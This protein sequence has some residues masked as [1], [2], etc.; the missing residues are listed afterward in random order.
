MDQGSWFLG[1]YHHIICYLPLDYSRHFTFPC[2]S[3]PNAKNRW[4]SQH[5]E[6]SRKRDGAWFEHPDSLDIC[7]P[8]KHTNNAWT[9]IWHI[10]CV[11]RE[12]GNRKIDKKWLV[13][14]TPV[15]KIFETMLHLGIMH[16]TLGGRG[17]CQC[18]RQSSIK[19][20]SL[21]RIHCCY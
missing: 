1:A 7:I 6:T 5:Q 18:F 11:M 3:Y 12:M 14:N 4:L 16:L 8:L 9:I 15:R 2:A 21:G 19:W 10:G 13:K 20:V 17:F